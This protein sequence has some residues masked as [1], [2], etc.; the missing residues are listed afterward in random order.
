MPHSD[1]TNTSPHPIKIGRKLY[2]TA[3]SLVQA[4]KFKECPVLQEVIRDLDP[5]AAQMQA[6][7]SRTLRRWDWNEVKV[8]LMR[9][10]VGLKIAQVCV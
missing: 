1:F 4:V 2:R 6:D 3:E 7:R 8:D 10:I 9:A 5:K